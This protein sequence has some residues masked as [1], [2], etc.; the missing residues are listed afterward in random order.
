MVKRMDDLIGRQAAIDVLSFEKEMLN[1]V[2]NDMDVVGAERETYSW[3]LGL[4]ESNIK[5]IEE[6]PP[7]ERHGRWEGGED[8]GKYC[9]V[10]H[11]RTLIAAC[12]NATFDG[13]E[14]RQVI[15]PFCMWCGARMD[16]VV[17]E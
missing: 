2:L 13:I 10:C 17:D 14:Y 6:L 3:G 16:E 5:D 15:T 8:A 9:S 4:I 11:Q 7:A 1:R 12:M